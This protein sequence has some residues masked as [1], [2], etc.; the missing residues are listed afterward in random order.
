VFEY[1]RG[2][3]GG[4]NQLRQPYLSKVVKKNEWENFPE[5]EHIHFYC[6]YIG[7]YPDLEEEKINNM[8][9]I[10]NEV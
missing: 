10:L 2:S 4:G 9:K 7:N 1:R 6:Y 8:C 3:S 5:V